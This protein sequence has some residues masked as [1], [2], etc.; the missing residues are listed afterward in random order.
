MVG[1]DTLMR[2][3]LVCLFTFEMDMVQ[4]PGAK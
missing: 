4:N 2:D 3:N 1:L